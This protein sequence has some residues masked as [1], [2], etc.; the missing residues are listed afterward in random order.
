MCILGK[1]YYIFTLIKHVHSKMKNTK[2]HEKHVFSKITLFSK[3]TYK[4][5]M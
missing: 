3:Y 5:K 2:K 4:Y 1:L